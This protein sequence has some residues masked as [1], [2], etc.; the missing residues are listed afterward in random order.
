MGP[1]PMKKGDV[2]LLRK[3][4]HSQVTLLESTAAKTFNVKF[5]NGDIVE[6]KVNM[7][8]WPKKAESTAPRETILVQVQKSMDHIKVILSPSKKKQAN[9]KENASE[10][11]TG[12]EKSA[13]GSTDFITC[14]I[15]N[16][17]NE[18]LS[19][20]SKSPAKHQDQSSISD[21]ECNM[22]GFGLPD[23][24]GDSVEVVIS[25]SNDI[26]D[27]SDNEEAEEDLDPDQEELEDGY[28]RFS[29]PENKEAEHE[30]SEA[31]KKKNGTRNKDGDGEDGLD[32]DDINYFTR[33]EFLDKDDERRRSR[34]T[35]YAQDKARLI[36]NKHI[37]T[38]VMKKRE[39]AMDIGVRV[40][41]R[42][43]RGNSRRCGI[44][45]GIGK[46]DGNTCM[47]QVRFDNSEADETVKQNQLT[48][49]DTDGKDEKFTWECVDEH[50]APNEPSEYDGT[51]IGVINFD[52]NMFDEKIDQFSES[53]TFPFFDLMKALYPGDYKQQLRKMNQAISMHN[54]STNS[55]KIDRV[56]EKE[57]WAFIG[58]LIYAAPNGEGGT[59]KLWRKND[60]V[61]G[62][63]LSKL[64]KK[65]SIEVMSATRFKTINTFFPNA[66]HGDKN[67]D[68][69]WY[70]IELLVEGFNNNREQRVAS[71]IKKIFDELMS[72]LQP[73]STSDGGLPHFSYVARKPRPY[74]TEFK[75]I[76][77]P[78]TGK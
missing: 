38:K 52:F 28:N 25:P 13:D 14:S 73:R 8:M 74:G 48:R 18:V 64:I 59:S 60:K 21:D 35:K 26:D 58:I 50:Y 76:C 67:S 9:E 69:P 33:E 23:P 6:K 61:A 10:D 5:E 31:L 54:D 3:H 63:K 7:L 32:E 19:A 71:S 29:L 40:M 44:I 37:I 47:L 57:W 56:T 20:L 65:K 16:E 15:N 27:I 17:S 1:R 24:V 68:D 70:K 77:C 55:K 49:E 4:P 45:T 53:Y 62:L 51:D 43:S 72:P 34:E 11:N 2:V 12:S 36:E 39:A 30:K 46:K 75:C 66:F 42:K 41:T 78:V 22:F